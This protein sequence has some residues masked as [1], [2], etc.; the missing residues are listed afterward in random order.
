L[1]LPVSFQTTQPVKLA[2]NII[3]AVP[4]ERLDKNNAVWL[5]YFGEEIEI[6]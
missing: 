5:P 4:F 6:L 1:P 2:I 3:L